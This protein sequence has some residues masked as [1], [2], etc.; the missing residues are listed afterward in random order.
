MDLEQ[1]EKEEKNPINTLWD[2]ILLLPIV[3]MVDS[4]RAQDMM[5]VMLEEI[6]RTSSRYV[7]LDIKGVAVV[8]SAVSNQ[9]IKVTKATALMG[10]TTIISG[11]TPGVAQSLVQLGI[12]LGDI[13][14][15]AKVSDA[16]GLALKGLGL[17]ITSVKSI[18]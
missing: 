13:V 8:D 3:G 4:K 2:N 6:E 10:C 17:R 11:I 16:L 7:I 1:I 9:L 12:D 14:T 15:T 18:N 5:D